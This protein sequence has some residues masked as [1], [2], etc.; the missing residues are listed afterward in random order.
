MKITASCKSMD[1]PGSL[2]RP[3]RLLFIL[4]ATNAGQT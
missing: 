2:V 1:P 3:G 4:Y